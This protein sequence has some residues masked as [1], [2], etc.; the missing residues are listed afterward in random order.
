MRFY[1]IIFKAKKYKREKGYRLIDFG[2]QGIGKTYSLF[3]Q[4]VIP[5]SRYFEVKIL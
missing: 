3:T 2:S 1:Y 5:T 4:G